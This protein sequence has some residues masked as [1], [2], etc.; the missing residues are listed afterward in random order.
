MEDWEINKRDLSGLIKKNGKKK[1]IELILSEICSLGV[2][3]FP[4][5]RYSVEAA[6]S[7]FTRLQSFKGKWST[8]S[9]RIREKLWLMN[10]PTYL[11]EYLS[12]LQ[13]EKTYWEIDII[14]DIFIEPSRIQAYRGKSG[15]SVAQ[16][17]K[18]DDYVK[19]AIEIAMDKFEQINAHTLREAL[20][21]IK[22][23]EECPHEKCTFTLTL[24]RHLSNKSGQDLVIFDACAGW[25]DRL[26]VAMALGATYYGVD[27]NTNSTPY[28]KAMI[29][30]FHRKD[31]GRYRIVSE[32]MPEAQIPFVNNTVD[33]SFLSP[34]SFDSEIY[35]D[36]MQQSIALWPN[37]KT[38]QTK[39]LFPTIDR[40]CELLNETGCL[41]VQ[42]ILSDE[43][44]AYIFTH[45]PE[46][47]HEGVISLRTQANRFKPMW[48]WRRRE[49]LSQKLQSLITEGVK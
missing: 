18:T 25:G 16:A 37:R 44:I 36:D 12:F 41:I 9:Y 31:D 1:T 42:S 49:G 7:L 15:I 32:A 23:V 6:E 3:T 24:F 26:I 20:Y 5:K 17:W 46:M 45:H 48:I 4:Y 47:N 38:W 43:I 40:C 14:T 21:F 33:I 30:T 35:S 13:S 11:G 27:P 19:R 39:F 8:N 22:N 2:D 10:T 34:P 28:F 29:E